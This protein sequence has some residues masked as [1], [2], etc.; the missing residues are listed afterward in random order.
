MEVPD[1]SNRH[2]SAFRLSTVPVLCV[3]P[4]SELKDELTYQAEVLYQQV[5]GRDA[6][7]FAQLLVKLLELPLHG[8]NAA[9]QSQRRDDDLTRVVGLECSVL[10]PPPSQP[11]GEFPTNQNCTQWLSY[12]A[13]SKA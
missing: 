13:R 9:K 4:A 10:T 11:T 12:N 6:F 3:R 8:S 2:I 1:L 7:Y 5:R